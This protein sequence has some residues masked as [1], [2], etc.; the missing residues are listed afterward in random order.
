[1]PSAI[2]QIQNYIHSRTIYSICLYIN[3]NCS[4]N[5]LKKIV[6]NDILLYHW[7]TSI[8]L[9]EKQLKK[10]KFTS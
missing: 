6:K 3:I 7:Y 5:Y 1:M 2:A 9:A 10:N 4:V 8:V